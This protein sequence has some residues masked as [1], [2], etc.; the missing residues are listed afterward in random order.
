MPRLPT[1]GEN[2]TDPCLPAQMQSARQP[3]RLRQTSSA[4]LAADCPATS[5]SKSKTI[6]LA[7]RRQDSCM[8]GGQTRSQCGDHVFNPALMGHHD[9]GIAFGHDHGSAVGNRLFGPRFNPYSEWLLSNKAVAGEFIYLAGSS[10]SVRPPKP[11]DPS[12]HI[13]NRKHQPVTKLVVTTA[14]FLFDRQ[15]GL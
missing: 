3:F 14:A 9:I 12:G 7:Y 13:E 5:L 4:R 2:R 8:A 6:R 10:P 15:P 1:Q 11:I